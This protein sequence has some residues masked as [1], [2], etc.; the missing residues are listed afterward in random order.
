MLMWL[1]SQNA[2]S[3]QAP[4]AGQRRGLVRNAFHQAAVAE[5]TQVRWST[6]SYWGD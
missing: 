4:G 6:M 5:D 1:S 3:L 2:M